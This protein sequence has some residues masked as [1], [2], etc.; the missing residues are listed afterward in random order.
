VIT[1][2]WAAKALNTIESGGQEAPAMDE[3]SGYP[4]HIPFGP[5]RL[6]VEEQERCQEFTLQLLDRTLRSYDERDATDNGSRRHHSNLDSARWK[7]HKT[8]DNVSLYSERYDE[9]RRDLHMP[10]DHWE[11]PAVLLAVGT[12]QASLDDVMLGLTVQ[13]FGDLQLR[14]ASIASQDVRGAMLAKLSGPTEEDPFQCLSVM[15]MVA[16]VGWPLAMV[17]RPRD[18]GNIYAYGV[19]SKPNGERVGYELVPPLPLPHLGPL[20]K[21]MTRAK[22]MYGALYTEQQDGPVDVY[23]QLYVDAMGSILDTIVMNAMWIA[24]QGFWKAPQLAEEKKLQ[25]CIFDSTKDS[26]PQSIVA[27]TGSCCGCAAVFRRR[28]RDRGGVCGPTDACAVCGSLLCSKCRT[29]RSF[30]AL[31]GRNRAEPTRRLSVVVCRECLAVVHR[32]SAASLAWQQH[33]HREASSTADAAT[34]TRSSLSAWSLTDES[35]LFTLSPGR[36][37][38]ESD[39]SSSNSD[40]EHSFTRNTSI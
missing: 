29:K 12:M 30:R 22:V 17:V 40:F 6:T 27:E 33:R 9:G 19:L 36:Y 20:P 11:N 25:W 34:T 35:V 24:A 4:G 26:K 39:F 37:L 10:G 2:P 31:T 28:R 32:Q 8:L 18:F 15:W 14:S 16:Q 38:S 21:P 1:A 5:L 13:T 23:I 7:R 3:G